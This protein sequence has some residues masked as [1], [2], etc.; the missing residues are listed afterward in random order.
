MTFTNRVTSITQD[1]ILPKVVDTVLGDNFITFRFLSNAQKWNGHELSRPL[2]YQK[3]GLGG[4]FSGLDTHSTATAET[5]ILMTYDPRGY[6]MPIAI[7]G[8]D[9]AV[10]RTEAEVLNLVRVEVE[11]AQE[12]ALDSIGTMLYADG[13]G[14]S[15][16]D[17]LGFDAL[18]DDG[19][20][21][22]TIGG[23]SR[24]TYATLA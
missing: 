4:S 12:D 14:N 17:F 1:E 3:S 6:E 13:T 5:R 15:D 11:S 8:M 19:T 23:L 18:I 22:G 9:K 16:K 20:S 2:K 10:N 7:A 21:V 24:T